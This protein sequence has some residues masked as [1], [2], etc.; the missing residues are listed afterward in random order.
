MKINPTNTYHQIYEDK[1]K[2]AKS[3]EKDNLDSKK[4]KSD[5]LELSPEILKYGP[6]KNRIKEG[7]YENEEVLN[8]VSEKLLRELNL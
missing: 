6:I 4:V 5:S 7:F 3:E 8:K 1:T 2:K